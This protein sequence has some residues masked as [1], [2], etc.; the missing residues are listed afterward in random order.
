MGKS[1]KHV[2]EVGKTLVASRINSGLS[3][4]KCGQ[5]NAT[6]KL[7]T[8]KSMRISKGHVTKMEMPQKKAAEK[9]LSRGLLGAF[10]FL[11]QKGRGG[12]TRSE[13]PLMGVLYSDGY[14]PYNGL[15]S[16]NARVRLSFG[17]I[18][19]TTGKYLPAITVVDR[20]KAAYRLY[21]SFQLIESV[22]GLH[23]TRVVTCGYEVRV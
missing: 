14:S 10:L 11:E 13:L 9:R 12:E 18:N 21:E 7:R 8:G 5:L 17:L 22:D 3:K 20:K 19:A 16:R 2:A 15:R 23:N 4:N 6:H 1:S